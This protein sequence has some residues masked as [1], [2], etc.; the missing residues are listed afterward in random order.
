MFDPFETIH[1]PGYKINIFH[2]I[3]PEN[4]RLSYDNLGTLAIMQCG[5]EEPD[6]DFNLKDC[7][8]LPVYLYE[9]GGV[10]YNTTGFH[11]PWDSGQTGYIYVKKSKVRKEW[12]VK[13]I[14]PRIKEVVLGCLKTEVKIFGAYINGDVFGYIVE[15]E[16]GEEIDSCWGFYGY[17]E[18][19]WEYMLSQAKG[20]TQ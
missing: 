18:G 1:V 13:H 17:L 14:S 8:W 2:D 3:S 12:D 4:P 5:D 9:H 19:D 15:N 7:I 10:A 16:A 11:C 6:P 20:A